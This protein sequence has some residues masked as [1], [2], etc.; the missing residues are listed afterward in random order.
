MVSVA[1]HDKRSCWVFL[2]CLTKY[3]QIVEEADTCNVTISWHKG[4][5]CKQ[6]VSRLKIQLLVPGVAD[7]SS[8]F[9]SDWKRC[10]VL[11]DYSHIREY[12][13][14]AFLKSQLFRM[15]MPCGLV[16]IILSYHIKRKNLLWELR[17]RSKFG[18]T[19][20]VL[21]TNAKSMAIACRVRTFH[22]TMDPMKA[23]LWSCQH[24]PWFWSW[25]FLRRNVICWSSTEML[26]V[27][28]MAAWSIGALWFDQRLMSYLGSQMVLDRFLV[29]NCA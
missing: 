3:K 23:A 16:H 5:T 14:M 15:N 28:M 13:H 9:F 21:Q 25:H 6:V 18:R 2:N 4:G 12:R 1:R 26:T 22:K 7:S 8:F 10:A 17:N 24:F 20:R 19:F 11:F 27:E 29:G